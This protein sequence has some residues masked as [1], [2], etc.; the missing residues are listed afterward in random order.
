MFHIESNRASLP[1]AFEL[2]YKTAAPLH[3]NWDNDRHT[4]SKQS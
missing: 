3:C 1:G 2:G 4:S